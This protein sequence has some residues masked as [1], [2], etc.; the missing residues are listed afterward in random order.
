MNEAQFVH[1]L[2]SKCDFGH[3]ETGNVLGE[4]LV[5]DQHGHQITTRQELHEHV[6][7]GRILERGM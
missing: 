5:L 2:Q 6:K 4:D 3:V 7:E 1:C